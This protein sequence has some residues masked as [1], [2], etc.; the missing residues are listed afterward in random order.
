M[1]NFNKTKILFLLFIILIL[2]IIFN[3]IYLYFQKTNYENYNNINKLK[4]AI[5]IWGELRGVKS[6]IE[7]FYINLIK[8]LNADVF[9]MVQ[10]TNDENMDSSFDLFQENVIEKVLYDRPDNIKDNYKKFNELN[11]KN[12]ENYIID[13][14]LQV[15][16]NFYKIYE[17]F[18]DVFEE[19]YD[20]IIF[21][22]SDFLHMFPFPDMLEISNQTDIFWCYDGSEWGGVNFNLVC[23][24][25]FYVKK[26][27]SNF[28]YYL[29]EDKYINKLK[30]MSLNGEKYAKFI[31]D[32]NNWKIGKIENNAFIT[33]DSN[34]ERTTWNKVQFSEKYNVFYKYEEQLNNT[35]D[36]L[37]KYNDG[38]K[39]KY[40]ETDYN[41]LILD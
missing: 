38:K 41:R 29:Q 7:K 6:T 36:A 8:P 3:F 40:I 13:S 26:Y 33:T 23:V 37:Q 2:L 39:W 32:D 1:K 20:Y 22:R 14:A 35:Y 10:K 11:E 4:Y 15:Y 19:K 25:S 21:T 34:N 9:L 30:N 27:I 16:Y 24:P 28:Y 31:F 5:C 17:K 12:S 18:G